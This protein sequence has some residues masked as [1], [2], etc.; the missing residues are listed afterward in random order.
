MPNVGVTTQCIYC[1]REMEVDFDI[2]EGIP[3]E[4]VEVEI[5]MPCQECASGSGIPA[6]SANNTEKAPVALA[7]VYVD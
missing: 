1:G 4:T 7:C 2:P 5:S 6:M 3:E